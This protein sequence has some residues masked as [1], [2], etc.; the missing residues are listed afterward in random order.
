MLRASATARLL[1][2]GQAP[3]A[4]VHASGLPFDDASGDRLRDWMGLDRATFYDETRIAFLPMGL[5]FPGYDSKGSDL[6]PRRECAKAWHARILALMPDVETILAVG[7]YAQRLHAARLGRPL[8]KLAK[9]DDTVRNWRDF[10]DLRP[11]LIPTPHPSWRNTAWLRRNPWFER[12]LLPELR[13]AVQA[14]IKP[15]GL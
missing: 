8:P 5:C 9:V 12:Q 13:A 2:A 15:Q 4:R 3:G 11:R 7:G 6:P 1:V 10:G 14:A